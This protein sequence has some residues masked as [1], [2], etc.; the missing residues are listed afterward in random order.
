MVARVPILSTK[1]P[2]GGEAA[3]VRSRKGSPNLA[4]RPRAYQFTVEEFYRMAEDGILRKDANVELIEGEIVMLPPI[5]PGHA[6][7]THNSQIKLLRLDLPRCDVRSQQPVR[8][9]SISEP[10]PDIS[11]VKAKRYAKSH[12]VASDVF[13]ILEV[14]NTSLSEDMGRKRLM[15]AEAAIPEYWVL[16]LAGARLIVYSRPKRGDYTEQRV[17]AAGETA[18][19]AT[20]KTLKVAVSDLLP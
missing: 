19:S 1:Q 20:L 3:V 5:D 17:F 18:Q 14:A 12:P 11:I 16:D 7:G 2:T 15:Y 8:L 13:L 6:Q 10:V 4:D 9:S